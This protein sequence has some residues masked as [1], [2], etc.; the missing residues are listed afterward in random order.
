VR[1]ISNTA[2]FR[3]RIAGI[4][5]VGFPAAILAQELVGPHTPDEPAANY[6]AMAAQTGS[7]LLGNALLLVS[8]IL[9]V[10]AVFGI[11]HLV[12]GRGAALVHV[13]AVLGV[14]GALGHAALAAVSVVFVEMTRVGERDAMVALLARLDESAAVGAMI[15]PLVLSFGF[16]MLLLTLALWRA[17]VVPAWVPAVVV[18]ALALHLGAP[19]DVA[20]VGLVTNALGGIAFAYVGLRVLRLSDTEWDRAEDLAVA[21]APQLRPA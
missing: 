14:L 10:P 16:G 3:R 17:R 18:A 2:R 9:L 5:L 15:F 13:G 19:E 20:A 8:A 4:S 11:L 1:D 21:S 12:R 6:D 7:L